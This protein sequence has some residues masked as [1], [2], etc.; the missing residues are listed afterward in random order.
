MAILTEENYVSKAE[1][2][3]KRVKDK[4]AQSEKK[5]KSKENDKLTISKIRNLLSLTSA[6]YDELQTKEFDDLLDRKN[7]L[8]VQLAYQSGR[9]NA[10]KVFVEEAELILA[11]KECDTK[12]K[13][14]RYCRYMEALV[15]Y[16]KYYGGEDQ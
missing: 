6:M 13:L 16:F 11:L 10:V 1:N 4:F 15:A 8:I 5:R 12:E 2:V 9:E 14:I 3:I 7:Y